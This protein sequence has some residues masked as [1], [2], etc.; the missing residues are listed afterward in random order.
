[1]KG[2]TL[3]RALA[4]VGLF[5]SVVL[6]GRDAAAQAAKPKTK[7]AAEAASAGI[8]SQ[9]LA[10]LKLAWQNLA[11]G[12]GDL[13]STPADVKGDT[14]KLEG[15]IRAAM[16]ALHGID[17]RAIPD[18]PK[19]LP[20]YDPGRTRAYILS[21]VKGHLDKARSLIEGA[22]V[23]SSDVQTAVQNINVGDTDVAELQQMAPKK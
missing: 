11:V 16:D 5:C 1:M 9:Q 6:N 3:I 22:K 15:H 18:A 14:G 13:L 7:P 19:K 21:A 17:P 2:S 8:S 23:N 12:Y 10:Q 20:P 4:V